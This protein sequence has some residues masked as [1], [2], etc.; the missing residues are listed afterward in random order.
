M[1]DRVGSRHNAGGDKPLAVVRFGREEMNQHERPVAQDV[2]PG[3]PVTLGADDNGKAVW[4][5]YTAGSPIYVVNEARGRGMDINTEEGYTLDNGED[6]PDIA[7]GLKPSG[8]GLHLRVSAVDADA[9]VESGTVI[10]A[11][12]GEGFVANGDGELF[13][14]AEVSESITIAAGETET[15][16]VEVA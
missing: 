14:V 9:T 4:E 10:T 12:E 2:L 6:G 13:A 5:A 3:E 11:D 15:V 16:P 8:G 7:P 1:A